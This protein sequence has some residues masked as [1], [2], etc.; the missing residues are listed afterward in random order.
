MSIESAADRARFLGD[1]GVEI[2][3]AT[4]AAFTAIFDYED[5]EREMD[6]EVRI[7]AGQPMLTCRTSDI[8]GLGRGDQ[9]LVDS[10]TYA[11]RYRTDD[12]TGISTVYLQS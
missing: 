5:D 12:S 6:G 8:S 3:R 2:T 10:T 7:V 4:G 11:V 1:F 9:L